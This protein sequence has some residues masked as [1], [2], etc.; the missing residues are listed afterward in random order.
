MQLYEKVYSADQI[1][2]L[3][4]ALAAVEQADIRPEGRYLQIA[5]HCITTDKD[6]RGKYE[7]LCSNIFEDLTLLKVA[8][9]EGPE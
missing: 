5:V 4:V 2:N 7:L 1:T 3:N 9:A 8:K 6:C